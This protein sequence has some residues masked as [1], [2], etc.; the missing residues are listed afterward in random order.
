[1]ARVL[2]EFQTLQGN[3]F[4]EAFA[5]MSSASYGA[6]TGA[7][8]NTARLH[9]QVVSQRMQSLG[10]GVAARS[11]ATSSNG[12]DGLLLAYNGPNA[13][14][15]D[16]KGRKCDLCANTPYHWDVAGG[17]PDGKQAC[18]EVCPVG[19]IQ[20]TKE[21]PIQQGD[22]GYRVNLRTKNWRKLG[23]MMD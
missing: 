20:F 4:G 16:L 10:A 14:L 3:Q 23:F 18:V 5:G 17:G 7:A 13:S 1:M 19:A 11:A 9:A 2:G 21:I 6:S 8:L 22:K 12:L 15:G